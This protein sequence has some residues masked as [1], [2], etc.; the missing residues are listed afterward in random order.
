MT[1]LLADYRAKMLRWNK[2]ILECEMK[3]QFLQDVAGNIR[4]PW[5]DW[6]SDDEQEILDDIVEELWTGLDKYEILNTVERHA[7]LFDHIPDG[8]IDFVQS[9]EKQ[10]EQLLELETALN[11][12]VAEDRRPITIPEDFKILSSLVG[13]LTGPGFG[14]DQIYTSLYFNGA[15]MN[16]EQP[17]DIAK[18]I[19]MLPENG[20]EVVCGW[21][22]A[23]DDH[24]TRIYAVYMR[25]TPENKKPKEFTWE[26]VTRF[27]AG[28]SGDNYKSVEELI[29][30][31]LKTHRRGIVEY[32]GKDVFLL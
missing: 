12:S 15:L 28:P 20:F 32:Q 25:F 31:W 21:K 26:Y 5:E 11:E 30:G 7:D 14:K 24:Q 8:T 17:E 29:E 9:S 10:A 23:E 13:G 16:M 3:T 18:D 22:I 6:D 4:K 27:E 2:E 19:D 1:A